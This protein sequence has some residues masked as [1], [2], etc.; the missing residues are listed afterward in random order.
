VHHGGGRR[1]AGLDDDGHRERDHCA[2]GPQTLLAHATTP[3]HDGF[4]QR[5]R[6]ED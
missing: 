5:R 4:T 1:L 2:D 3:T 6:V